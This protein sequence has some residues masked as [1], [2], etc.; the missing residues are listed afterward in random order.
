MSDNLYYT[1]T[2]ASINFLLMLLGYSVYGIV[3]SCRT[4]C[5]PQAKSVQRRGVRITK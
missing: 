2:I 1:H 3:K 5:G 4:S